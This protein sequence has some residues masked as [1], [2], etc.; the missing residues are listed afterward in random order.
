MGAGYER[1][2]VDARAEYIINPT[3]A[4]VMELERIPTILLEVAAVGGRRQAEANAT[5]AILIPLARG[6]NRGRKI[7]GEIDQQRS[8]QRD[9]VVGDGGGMEEMGG[10]VSRTR[11]ICD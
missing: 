1:P 8:G 4:D 2:A 11:A 9:F 3:V 5:D 7:L 6:C 10:L